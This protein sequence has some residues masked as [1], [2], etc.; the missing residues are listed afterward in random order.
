MDWLAALL[1]VSL[2]GYTVVVATD[3]AV[4]IASTALLA[5]DF[6]YVVSRIL[7]QPNATCV[8]QTT[9]AVI[10]LLLFNV[11]ND[12]YQIA[13]ALSILI[14]YFALEVTSRILS[15]DEKTAPP[16]YAPVEP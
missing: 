1:M 13:L 14:L 15:V 3:M 2:L 6:V 12:E 10:M 11:F 4:V 8:A 16:A 9:K 7:S 5:A